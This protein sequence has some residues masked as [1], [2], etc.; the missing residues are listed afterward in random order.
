M[1]VVIDGAARGWP[2]QVVVEQG[3]VAGMVGDT[4][5]VV[6]RDDATGAVRA[7]VGGSDGG[8]ELPVI[9]A[10]GMAWRRFYPDSAVADDAPRFRLAPE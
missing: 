2:Y 10:D 3:M 7:A 9:I 8:D 4:P 5:V 1:G 6:W